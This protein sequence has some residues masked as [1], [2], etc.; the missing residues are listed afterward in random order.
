M[1]FVLVTVLSLITLAGCATLGTGIHQDIS[2]ETQA[3]TQVNCKLSNDK[4]SWQLTA[5]GTITVHRS[6]HRLT[7]ICQKLGYE[8]LFK[9]VESFPLGLADNGMLVGIVGTGIDH[10]NGAAYDYPSHVKIALSK[11]R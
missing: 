4:G 3:L 7:I 11:L 8:T 5:P 10:L 1:R 2:L 6:Q 9:Q